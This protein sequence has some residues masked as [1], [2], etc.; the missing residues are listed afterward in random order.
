MKPINPARKKTMD[1]QVGTILNEPISTVRAPGTLISISVRRAPM[2]TTTTPVA[3]EAD[4]PG[5]KIEPV[6]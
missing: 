1:Q 4:P 6:L 3:P 5:A 2:S